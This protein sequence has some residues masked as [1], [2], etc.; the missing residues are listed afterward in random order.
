MKRALKFLTAGLTLACWCNLAG[1]DLA[2]EKL[3]VEALKPATP[4][5]LYLADLV[6]EHVLDGRVH[7]ID[8]ENFDYR[9][10]IGTGLFGVTALSADSSELYVAT[11]YYTKR[12]RGKRFDQFE[13]YST[14]DLSLKT[15]IE[16][17]AKHA[18]ALGYKGTIIGSS[19]SRFVF[20]QNATPA[21]SVTVID[22]KA[23]K[24]TAE[25][26]TP[27]CWIAL[28]AKSNPKRFATLCGD[29][30]ALTIT[31]NDQGEAASQKRSAKLFDAETDPL[32]VQ[33]EHIGD[34]NY[35][36]SYEGNIHEINLGGDVAKTESTW[37]LLNDED[38]AAHW[39][40]GGYQLLAVHDK[41]RRLYVA[42]HDGG[43]DGSH[44]LPAKEIWVFDLDS[45]KRLHRVAGNNA[46]ALSL[47]KEDAP[48]LYVYD[49]IQ[50]KFHK[51]V[52]Q[53]ALKPVAESPRFGDFA[54]LFESH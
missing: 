33:A 13:A 22:R 17:P 51:Y 48:T 27:G 43:R 30:T 25:I 28:P 41:T 44:K 7:I 40:P 9:G 38:K 45:K 49:G 10:L 2:A 50:A 19:D 21:S 20:I 3:S 46:I 53:P 26:A 36:V 52:T 1:A 4:H 24:F 35:F 14:T 12:N 6:L 47:T 8:G 34:T 15:E 37:S 16:I 11:T 31:L 39:K 5:R 32:F 23:E 29:G 42:M 18:Q 54:T